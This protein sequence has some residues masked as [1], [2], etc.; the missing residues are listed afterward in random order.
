MSFSTF[1][2]LDY[3]LFYLIISALFIV[4]LMELSFA[5]VMKILIGAII[6]ALVFGTISNFIFKKKYQKE[7]N[8][9]NKILT[10]RQ[11]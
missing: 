7:I 1:R 11:R 8:K 3:I 4:Q 5:S 2:K 6:L 9:F 10:K